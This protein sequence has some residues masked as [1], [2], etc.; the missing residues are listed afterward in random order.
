MSTV[1]RVELAPTCHCGQD[2]VGH[3]HPVVDRERERAQRRAQQ[4]AL[5]DLDIED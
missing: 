3:V 2:S 5:D 4:A 1:E